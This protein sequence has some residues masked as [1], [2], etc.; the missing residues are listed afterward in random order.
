MTKKNFGKNSKKRFMNIEWNRLCAK[1]IVNVVIPIHKARK[2]C[3]PSFFYVQ[4]LCDKIF[5][6]EITFGKAKQIYKDVTELIFLAKFIS[7]R[8]YQI[9]MDIKYE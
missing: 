9:T 5:R 4:Y 7:F 1:F 6:K 2:E 3:L 8:D